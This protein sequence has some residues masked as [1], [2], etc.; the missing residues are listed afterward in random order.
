ME[1]CP[2]G[3]IRLLK[4]ENLG[5]ALASAAYGVLSTFR[6]NKTSFVSFADNITQFCDCV[7]APGHVVMNDIGIFA[8]SSPVSV[9]AAFLQKADYKYFNEAYGVDCWT[10]VKELKELGIAGE[11][12]PKIKE[13]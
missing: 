11:L 7:P 6:K 4:K 10:E 2:K 1:A 9:D 13:A 8:S 3:A 12:K 5:R